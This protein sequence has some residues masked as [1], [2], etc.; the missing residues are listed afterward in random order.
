MTS[1]DFARFM[2]DCIAADVAGDRGLTEDEIYGV[3]ISWCVLHCVR[4]RPCGEFWAAMSGLG[5]NERRRINRHYVRPGL[6]MTGPAAVDYVL[7][8][9]PGLAPPDIGECPTVGVDSLWGTLG[10]PPGTHRWP[11]MKHARD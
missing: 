1:G 6:R 9:R 8:S 7:A 10:T 3:Y 5:L 4:P 2:S 11:T